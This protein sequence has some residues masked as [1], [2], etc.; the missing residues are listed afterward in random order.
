MPLLEVAVHSLI[1]L[2]LS[3]NLLGFKTGAHLMNLIVEKKKV[4]MREIDLRYNGMSKLIEN[5]VNKMLREK[6]AREE[7]GPVDDEST[8]V[9]IEEI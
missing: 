8:T 2:N 6:S 3:R 1:T 4:R 5:S 9:R 7:D